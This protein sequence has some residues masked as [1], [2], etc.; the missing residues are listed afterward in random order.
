MKK[1]QKKYTK[2]KQ[3]KNKIV[4]CGGREDGSYS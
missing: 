1:Q 3:Q 4:K 2:R